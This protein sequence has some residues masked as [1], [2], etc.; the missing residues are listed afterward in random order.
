MDDKEKMIIRKTFAAS[1]VKEVEGEDRTFLVTIS[2]ANPDRSGDIVRPEGMV[3][4]N[5]LKN[6][7]VSAFHDYRSPA[8]GQAL[9]IQHDENSVIAKVKFA[10]K[11]TYPL[12]DTLHDLYRQGIMRAWSIGFMPL[13]SNILDGDGRE[14]TKWELL[15]FASVL[16]PANPEALTIMRTKGFDPDKI[17]EEQDKLFQATDEKPYPNEH[18]CRLREP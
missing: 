8:I 17:M 10:D 18:A 1:E 14:F 5:Y 16:V 11:G 6:P 3:I 7:V 13:E 4:D 15:E 12:A 9:E 2:T